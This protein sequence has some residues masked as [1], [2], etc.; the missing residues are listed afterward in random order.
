[1]LSASSASLHAERR[2]R[3]LMRAVR[4]VLRISAEAACVRDV[5]MGMARSGLAGM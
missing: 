4:V 3:G 5:E 1:V 2:S